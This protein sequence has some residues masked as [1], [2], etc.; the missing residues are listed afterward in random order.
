MVASLEWWLYS[1]KINTKSC[2]MRAY[3]AWIYRLL[4]LPLARDM[5]EKK[6]YE[7]EVIHSIT[8]LEYLRSL[9]FFVSESAV[10]LSK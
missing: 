2:C 5:M 8:I 1:Y 9:I 7:G 3:A 6:V 10:A 4:Q